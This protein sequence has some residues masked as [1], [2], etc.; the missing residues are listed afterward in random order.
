L[1][2]R[3]SDQLQELAEKLN[4]IVEMS[5][6]DRRQNLRPFYRYI[7]ELLEGKD[8]DAI[9]LRDSD[10]FQGLADRLNRL[11]EKMRSTKAG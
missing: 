6:G 5:T 1:V 3:E 8:P 7:D 2:L 10:Q 9:R 4:L 11:G